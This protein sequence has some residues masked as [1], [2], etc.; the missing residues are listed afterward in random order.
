MAS[1]LVF[2]LG[3]GGA[4]AFI[5][6]QNRAISLE[7]WLAATTIWFGAAT[8]VLLLS[9]VPLAPAKILGLLPRPT[10]PVRPTNLRPSELGAIQSLLLN[11]RDN[12]RVHNRQLQPRL[13]TL[14][15]HFL[16]VHHG[17]DRR[18]A[19]ERAAELLGDTGW[20]IDPRVTGRSPTMLEIRNFVDAVVPGDQL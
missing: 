16:L 18:A 5:A 13:E 12:E 8:V 7:I 19:P 15:D 4:L 2:A 11:A 1:A 20:L 14:A 10:R 9:R 6:A 17:I 3:F